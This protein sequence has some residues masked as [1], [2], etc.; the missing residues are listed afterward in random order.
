MKHRHHDLIVQWAADPSRVLEYSSTKGIWN[1]VTGSPKWD[2]SVEYRLA[3]RKHVVWLALDAEGKCFVFEWEA[4]A[5]NFVMN[6]GGEA[7]KIEWESPE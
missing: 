1:R 4:N 2:E 5:K 7:R 3:P 6:H